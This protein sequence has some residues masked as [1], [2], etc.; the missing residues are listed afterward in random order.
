DPVVTDLARRLR[1]EPVAWTPPG[2]AS[3]PSAAEGRPAGPPRRTTRWAP[4]LTRRHATIVGAGALAAV[5]VVLGIV[6]ARRG[7]GDP[8]ETL[9]AAAPGIVVV[10]FRVGDQNHQTLREGMVDLLSTNLDG[11][12]G[13]RAIDPPTILARWRREAPEGTDPDIATT[14][15][16]ARRTGASYAVVGSAVSLSEGLR[17]VTEIYD[18]TTG[19]LLGEARAEGAPDSLFAL[20]DRLSVEILR[21]I[22]GEDTGEL[23]SPPHLAAVTTTSLPALKAFLAGEARFRRSDHKGA[24]VEYER[25]VEADSTFARAYVR[26]SESWGWIGPGKDRENALRALHFIDRLPAREAEFLL[27]FKAFMVDGDPYRARALLAEF[28]LRHPDDSEAWFYLGETYVHFG[29]QMLAGPEEAQRPLRRAI[30]LVPDFAPFRIHRVEKPFLEAD[31][32]LA[33]SRLK[34]YSRLASGDAHEGG[35]RL[36]F[37]LGFGDPASRPMAEAGLDTLDME[38]LT[39]AA[40]YL[41]HAR[42]LPQQE[43]LLRYVLRRPDEQWNS[44][45]LFQNLVFQ[46]RVRDA[47]ALLDGFEI[48][49]DR[50]A[51]VLFYLRPLGLEPPAAEVGQVIFRPADSGLAMEDDVYPRDTWLPSGILA[52]D[53]GRWE[54]HGAAIEA[55]RK[56][57]TEGLAEGDTTRSRIDSGV[58]KGLDGYGAWR[59]GRPEEALRLLEAARRETVGHNRYWNRR[60]RWWLGDL[61]LELDRPREASRYFTSLWL[62]RDWRGDPFFAYE[63]G[64][65]Y[66]AAGDAAAAIDAYE[67]ALL[68]WRNADPEFRLRI[69][70]ARRAITRLSRAED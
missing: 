17:L 59:R 21:V 70:A 57:A 53:Q 47:M 9:A 46:G 11:A 51:V 30:A 26:L 69:E 56:A 60:I 2:A 4:G 58:A 49:E 28:L 10:P 27:A 65:A 66:E 64:R 52:A 15:E 44:H 61:L 19:S 24:I 37:R 12:G 5:V 32:V 68:A 48:S 36:A 6:T 33:A 39:L 29:A 16:I 55:F 63:A 67:Y 22:L 54:D 18:L 34:E 50:R 45:W 25:A 38:T 41:S 31:G 43:A 7:G 8:E 14:L 13:L 23:V 42:F 35:F 40:Y 3:L 62:E 1:Q 20:V